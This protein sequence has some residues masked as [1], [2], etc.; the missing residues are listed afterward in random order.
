MFSKLPKRAE[1]IKSAVT[2]VNLEDVECVTLTVVKV[3]GPHWYLQVRK[4]IDE[5][6]Q[7]N[8]AAML[9]SDPVQKQLAEEEFTSKYS[10]W[11]SADWNELEWD[12]VKDLR[13]RE[14]LSERQKMAQIAQQGQCLR[15]PSFLKHVGS[16]RLRLRKDKTD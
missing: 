5:H 4:G 9:N 12:K 15:C 16:S 8:V 14:L 13:V 1:D 2:A 11:E 10:D 6:D 3:R 7:I